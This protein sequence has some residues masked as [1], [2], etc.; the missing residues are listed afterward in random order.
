VVLDNSTGVPGAE[1]AGFDYDAL[2]GRF[3]RPLELRKTDFGRHPLFG[4]LFV[5][6]TPQTRGELERILHDDLTRYLLPR[7]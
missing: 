2:L 6:T 3:S 4:F 5:R 1:I 7:E